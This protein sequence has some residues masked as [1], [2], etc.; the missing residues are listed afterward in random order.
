MVTFED[1]K[2]SKE[3]STYINKGNELLG[4][5]GYTEHG[6]AHA[7]KTARKAAEILTLLGYD[8]RTIDLVKISGYMHDI[9]NCIN[10]F[11][12]AQSGAVMAFRILDHMGMSPDEVS[13]VIGAIG[14][15]DEGTGFAF[16]PIS[17]ALILADKSDVRRSRVRSRDGSMSDIHDRVNFAVHQ[18]ELI[19]YPDSKEIILNLDIDTQIS[20]VMEY[21]EIFLSRMKMCRKAAEYLDLNFELN[22]NNLRLL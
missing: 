5:M 12:H 17:A 19:V 14:N 4:E 21:F 16:S 9:G 3:I 10:R 22:I 20:A 18:S 1:I 11:D 7:E 15:H 8:E 13:D 6:F 2:K